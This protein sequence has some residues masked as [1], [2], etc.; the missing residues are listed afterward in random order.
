MTIYMY[1]FRDVNLTIFNEAYTPVNDGCDTCSCAGGFVSSELQGDP[2]MTGLVYY[3]EPCNDCIGQELC[4]G[5]LSP[6][7]LSFD[8][9]AFDYSDALGNMPFEGFTCLVCGWV[10]DPS[11]HDDQGYEPDYDDGDY[12]YPALDASD[13]FSF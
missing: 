12:D 5:C 13:Y 10:Y 9:S 11:R 3:F 8:L 4:P 6:L 7:S 2:P 1:P